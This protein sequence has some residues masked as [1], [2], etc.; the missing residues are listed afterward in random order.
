M[1]QIMLLM[2]VVAWAVSALTWAY[3]RI[4][5]AMC[6]SNNNVH[7]G[8]TFGV[9]WASP[10]DIV[11][12]GGEDALTREGRTVAAQSVLAFLRCPCSCTVH[13]RRC[14]RDHRLVACCLHACRVPGLLQ[15]AIDQQAP[16]QH[17]RKLDRDRLLFDVLWLLF[18]GQGAPMTRE[19]PQA[20]P[21]NVP[22]LSYKV[23]GQPVCR[24]GFMVLWGVG[25]T[26]NT[27]AEG[28]PPHS[29]DCS[30]SASAACLP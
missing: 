24:G 13:K 8:S 17:L 7:G 11:L 14:G 30:R 2:Q 1:I 5:L 18:N 10:D 22:K 28:S 26:R 23:L 4:Q 15:R 29:L 27:V 12:S 6:V 16:C 3:R 21:P 19:G 25:S 20:S 9:L